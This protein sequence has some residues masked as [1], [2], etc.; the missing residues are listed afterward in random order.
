MRIREPFD[1]SDYIF[2]LKMDGFRELAEIMNG[3]VRLISR[4]GNPYKSFAQRV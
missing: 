3:K 4:R 1:H 2:E